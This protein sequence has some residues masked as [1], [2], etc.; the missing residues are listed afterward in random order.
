MKGIGVIGTGNM[1]SALVRAIVASGKASGNSIVVYDVDREKTAVLEKDIG[2]VTASSVADTIRL[3]TDLIVLAVKPQILVEIL[4]EAAPHINGSHLVISIAAGISTELILSRI[5]GEARVIRAMPNVA[6]MVG[7]G[8]TALC[9]AG[10]ADQS[11]LDAAL[12]LFSAF[13][14]AVPVEEK[15]MNTVTALS[16]SGPGYVFIMMEALT[17]GAVLMGMDRPTAR[18]LAVQMVLGAAIMAQKEDAPFSDLKDRI[19]SPGGTTIA[20]LQAMERGGIRGI[21]MDTIQ[22]ATRRGEELQ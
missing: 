15:M 18:K 11:D 20:G 12:D 13:G 6:A 2:T 16:A 10:K 9:R 1:G 14:E 3:D 4:D 19:T 8:A 17:D 7:Y 21:L 22:A 5:T